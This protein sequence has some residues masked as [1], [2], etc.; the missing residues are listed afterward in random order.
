M[1]DDNN[2]PSKPETS[3]SPSEPK[4]TELSEGMVKRGGL[5]LQP[6]SARPPAPEGQAGDAG[7]TPSA[8]SDKP[9]SG[10]QSSDE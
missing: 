6:T 2:K 7:E 5:R 10:G 1:T 9:S 3:P 4:T 8:Q